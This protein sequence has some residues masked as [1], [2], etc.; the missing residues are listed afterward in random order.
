M[1]RNSGN[2]WT[3]L[4]GGDMQPGGGTLVGEGGVRQGYAVYAMYT[5]GADRWNLSL[6]LDACEWC[7][8]TLFGCGS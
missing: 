7:I 3:A 6:V 5:W 4:A 2:G 8:Q 1:A